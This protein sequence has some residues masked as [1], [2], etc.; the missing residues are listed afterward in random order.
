[1]IFVTVGNAT[2]GFRRLLDAIEPLVEAGVLPEKEVLIQT[3]CESGLKTLRCAQVAFLSWERFVETI[4]NSDLV[5]CHAG[6]GTLF[7]VLQAGKIPVVMPRR[8]KYGE[9]VD[10]HQ[11]DLSKV[12]ESEGRVILAYEPNELPAAI[13]IAQQRSTGHIPYPPSKMRS[14]VAKAINDLLGV[15]KAKTNED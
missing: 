2:Q 8:A 12:L 14:L 6:A 5:I 9:L 15:G 10:D 11:L 3:G 4:N 7:H 13:A 1:M